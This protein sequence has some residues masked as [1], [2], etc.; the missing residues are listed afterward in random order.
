MDKILTFTK[1]RMADDIAGMLPL[2]S[3]KVVIETPK[4]PIEGRDAFVKFIKDG[5]KKR[6]KYVPP[7]Q[8]EQAPSHERQSDCGIQALTSCWLAGQ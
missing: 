5:I 4:G 3:D 1:A 7:T 2:V 6:E 8:E